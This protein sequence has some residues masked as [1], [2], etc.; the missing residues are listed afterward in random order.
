MPYTISFIIRKRKQLDNL[1]ELPKEK[2]PPEYIIWDR[3]GDEIDRWID[4]VYNN[5]SKS[6]SIE[7][8]DTEVEG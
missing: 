4:R 5:K 7:F 3:G 6:D 1:S 8:W 2:R